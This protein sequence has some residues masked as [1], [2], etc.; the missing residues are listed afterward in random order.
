MDLSGSRKRG[1]FAE[2]D[3]VAKRFCTSNPEYMSAFKVFDTDGSG[4]IDI[5]ELNNAL[6]AVKRS[7]ESHSMTA[8]FR[9][10]FNANTV[11]WLAARFS[12]PAWG[13]IYFQQFAEMMQY[14]EGLKAIFEQIDTDGTGDL[15]VNELSRALNLSG[16]SVTGLPGG[17]DP[18]SLMVAERIGRAYDADH[19]G[20]LSFD[21]FVQLR[22]EWDCYLGA[23]AAHVPAGAIAI[24]PNELLKVLDAV[25]RSLE[26]MGAL[27]VHPCMTGLAGFSCAGILGTLIYNSMFTV[28]RPFQLRTAELL[29]GKFSGGSGLLSF[30][31]FCMLMEFLKAQKAKFMAVDQSR[32]GTISLTDLSNAFAASG[33]PMPVENLV[34]LGRRYDQDNSGALE[35]DEFLQMMCELKDELS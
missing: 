15:S 31:Q 21:E 13:A 3:A 23:W 18:L 24:S 28:Q 16:F 27:A 8:F 25:K 19:N 10:P 22:L 30:E 4:T 20:A 17:G 29:I 26:P 5:C 1:M 32:N 14:L 11:L 12:A 7:V 33:L 6:Q 9:A 35:F 34:A 2:P